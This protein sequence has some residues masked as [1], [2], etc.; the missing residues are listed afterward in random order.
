MAPG[1]RRTVCTCALIFARITA[2]RRVESPHALTQRSRRTKAQLTRS[3]D[4]ATPRYLQPRVHSIEDARL[5]S[6]FVDASFVFGWNVHSAC[7]ACST[8]FSMRAVR[9]VAAS[10]PSCIL[11][12]SGTVYGWFL[13]HGS[14]MKAFCSLC[15]SAS[16]CSRAICFSSMYRPSPRTVT[17]P[18]AAAASPF[19]FL[20]SRTLGAKVHSFSSAACFSF[21]SRSSFAS[22]SRACCATRS[23]TESVSVG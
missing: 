18:P 7:R 11:N 19:S 2:E 6:C 8:S 4:G 5:M 22:R 16:A 21:R 17:S 9:S 23:S 12:G 10:P 13:A 20:C 14:R 15:R 1:S 3:S